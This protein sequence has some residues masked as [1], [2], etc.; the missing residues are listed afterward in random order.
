VP[1]DDLSFPIGP[2]GASVGAFGSVGAEL[3]TDV[4]HPR[5]RWWLHGLLLAATMVSSTFMGALFY[6][7][8]PLEVLSLPLSEM[9]QKPVFVSVGLSFS[10]PLL[11]ILLAHESGHYV[12]AR[13]HGLQVT[14]PFFL[15]MP[16]PA[17]LFNPGTLGAVIRIREP[18]RRRA[19]LLDVGAWGPV[20]GFAVALPVLVIGLALSTVGQVPAG[21]S[22]GVFFG[23]PLLFVGLARGVFFP[24][25]QQGWDIVL[26][27]M[28]WAGWWG[29]FITA[30]NM[31]PFWQLDG[32]HVAY[33]MFGARHRRWARPL[34]VLLAL[35]AVISQ[36]WALWVAILILVGPEHP[37]VE[38]E[39]APLDSHRRLL[40]WTALMIFV[41]CFSF[42]PLRIIP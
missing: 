28:A 3:A 21:H 30:L 5:P 12:A 22:G 33:A 25:L 4:S 37:P 1:R 36:V 42:V 14:P 29:L 38:D 40:G 6:G 41:L 24:G 34:L 39:N 17:L 23:E 7:G 26:H 35:V 10:I 8:L 18:I 32:G 31:L 15:P 16:I 13:R 9:V 19:Q 11:L 27:P 20:S 2:D